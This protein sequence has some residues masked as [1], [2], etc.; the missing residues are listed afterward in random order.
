MRREPTCVG[1]GTATRAQTCGLEAALE[2]LWLAHW[3]AV[4]E[5]CV[6]RSSGRR[7]S[8]SVFACLRVCVC[9]CLR[10]CVF[11][12]VR[13]CVFACLRVCVFACLHVC[14]FACLRVCVFACLRVCVFACLRVCVFACLR[15]CMFA[16]LRVCVFACLR[17]CVFACLR[18]CVFAYLE[19][20]ARASVVEQPVRLPCVCCGTPRAACWRAACSTIRRVRRANSRFRN[21]C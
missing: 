15:V 11:A 4:N 14:V 7:K 10:V 19:S 21:L 8:V 6:R 12:C 3:D 18:V 17:V 9:T 13:V 1:H 2:A 16:C 20:L 5:M